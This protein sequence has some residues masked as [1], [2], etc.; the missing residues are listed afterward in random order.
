M[1]DNRR[2]LLQPNTR[3]DRR[4]SYHA[5]LCVPIG[6]HPSLTEALAWRCAANSR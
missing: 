3:S 2:Q 4:L 6:D 5:R 1:A